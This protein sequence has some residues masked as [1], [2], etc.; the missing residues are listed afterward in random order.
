[1]VGQAPAYRYLTGQAKQ[2]SILYCRLYHTKF[3][4][5]F[6]KNQIFLI[7]ILSGDTASKSSRLSAFQQ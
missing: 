6:N 1:M 4:G 2:F 3:P 7:N 5:M